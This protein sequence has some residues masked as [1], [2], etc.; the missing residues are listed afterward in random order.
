[1]S[2]CN[3]LAAAER[4]ISRFRRPLL[5]SHRRPDG[6]ALGALAAV[7]RILSERGAAPTALL[8]EPIPPRYAFLGP[9]ATWTILPGDDAAPRRP[10]ESDALVILDTCSLAQLEPIAAWLRD[11]PPMLVIDH[12]ATRDALAERPDDFR[13][14]DESASAAC[15]IVFELARA[16]GVRIDPP[17]AT[18]LFTGIATDCGW[19]RY[20]NTDARTLRAAAELIEAGAAADVIH[21][22]V[23]QQDPPGRLRLLARMLSSLELRAGG[24]LA[25][26]SIR[27]ADF[28]AAGADRSMTEDLVNEA[29]RLGCV[30]ATALFT[31]D[32]DG[33]VRVNL[34]SKERVDVARVA[35]TFGG[36]GHSRAAGARVRGAWDEVVGNVTAALERELRT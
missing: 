6:D 36:G 2:D 10:A 25:V 23:Y 19:F 27:A 7:H 15:L 26:L 8:Y 22:T 28:A 16:A 17:T 29:G 12:H 33:L 13:L 31:E 21:R 4:W 30:E 5:V 20:S 35:A 18:A 32:G 11:A 24:R 3:M 14:F 34:R 1:M 9:V